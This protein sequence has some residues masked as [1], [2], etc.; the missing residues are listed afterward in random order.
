MAV[1]TALAN[2]VSKPLAATDYQTLLQQ[3]LPYGPA[4]TD[5]PDAGI[6]RLFTGLAQELAR[7]DTRAWQLIEEADPRTTL[8]CSPTGSASRDYQIRV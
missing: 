8:N 3:L 5:D 4:W 6:T 7:L 1:S 2:Q